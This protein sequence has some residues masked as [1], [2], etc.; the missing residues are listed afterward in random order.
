MIDW[1]LRVL[2]SA[3]AQSTFV[4]GMQPAAQPRGMS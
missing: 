2:W 3:S 1:S 4:S